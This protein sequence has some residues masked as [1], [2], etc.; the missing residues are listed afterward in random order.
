MEALKITP[1]SNTENSQQK[2]LFPVLQYSVQTH[3]HGTFGLQLSLIIT[4]N[5]PI[6]FL[7]LLWQLLN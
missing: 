7:L 4:L 6:A 1:S 3:R 2:G 5:H